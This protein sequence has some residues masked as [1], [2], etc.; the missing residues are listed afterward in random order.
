MNAVGRANGYLAIGEGGGEKRLKFG[1]I[2]RK[3]TEKRTNG[4]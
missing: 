1:G 2:H 3:G 4:P